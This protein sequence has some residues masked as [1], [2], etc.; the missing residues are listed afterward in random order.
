MG[1]VEGRGRAGAWRR[2]AKRTFNKRCAE[3]A[4]LPRSALFTGA[5]Q[6]SGRVPPQS[7]RFVGVSR[8]RVCVHTCNACI[9]I[10]VYTR[11]LRARV[12]ITRR[13]AI[14]SLPPSPRRRRRRCLLPPPL[15]SRGGRMD[16]FRERAG[17]SSTALTIRDPE[18]H[19][20][21]SRFAPRSTFVAI[22]SAGN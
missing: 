8:A 16:G 14:S 11:E 7:S 12:C 22:A 17:K 15:P 21:H 5:R 3:I 1:T 19:P 4:P 13:Q 10:Y 2:A 6:L 18:T 9:F 20:P